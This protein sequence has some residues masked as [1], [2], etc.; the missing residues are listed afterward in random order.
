MK[1][2]IGKF[3]LKVTLIVWVSSLVLYAVLFN[4][5]DKQLDVDFVL[6]QLV[7]PT[8]TVLLTSLI[9]WNILKSRAK[10][11]DSPNMEVPDFS[12]V[13]HHKLPH[14]KDLGI[15]ELIKALPNRFV[16]AHMDAVNNKVKLYEKPS[17]WSWG[18]G[19]II[20]IRS[21]ETVVF[22]FPYSSH[23]LGVERSREKGVAK[24]T[25]SL[26]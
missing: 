7:Y 11:M 21:E 19:Y 23:P 14:K 16:I 22:S 8:I 20:E 13:R 17:F 25:T 10:Y 1:K 24:L 9:W 2:Y 12:V 3:I 5:F 15:E 6:M 18:N 26:S 4:W